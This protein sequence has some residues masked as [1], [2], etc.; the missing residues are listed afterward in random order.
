MAREKTTAA[1][2]APAPPLRRLRLARPVGPRDWFAE[3]EGARY[4]L[5]LQRWAAFGAGG[6]RYHDPLSAS[7]PAAT[8]TGADYV[9]AL[10]EGRVVLMR[11]AEARGAGGAVT[12][13]RAGPIG[14]YRVAN[15]A[16][17]PDGLR[18]DFVERIGAF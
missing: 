14:L 18:F 9:E 6:G 7:G 5:A 4:P 10:R 1:T 16:L 11:S 3:V 13:R 15:V 12:V 2:R 8:P 17:D